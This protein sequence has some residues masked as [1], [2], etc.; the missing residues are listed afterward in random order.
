MD[1]E[2]LLV[3]VVF[4]LPYEFFILAEIRFG[5]PLEIRAWACAFGI[6]F[7]PE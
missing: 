3:I 7:W 4:V 6:M 5:A 2:V 1:A